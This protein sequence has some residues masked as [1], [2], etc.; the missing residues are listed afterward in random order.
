M[1]S[2]GLGRKELVLDFREYSVI[3]EGDEAVVVGTIRDPVN[4]DFS[5]RIC[6]DDVVGMTRLICRKEMLLLLLRSFFKP[7]KK[8]HWTGPLNEHLAEGRTRLRSAEEKAL[9]RVQANEA[10]KAVAEAGPDTGGEQGA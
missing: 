10:A 8:N 5:I 4:W 2:R 9:D 6:E 7:R 1:K 3:R